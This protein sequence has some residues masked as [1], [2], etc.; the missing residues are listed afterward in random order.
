MNA[1][2]PVCVAIRAR[3][4]L[5]RGR[6]RHRGGSVAIGGTG[7]HQRHGRSVDGQRGQRS[8]GN[9]AAGS[10][11]GSSSAGMGGS[12]G[13]GA[14]TNQR[15]HRSSGSS[16]SG[17]CCR[18]RRHRG[19]GGAGGT[20]GTTGQLTRQDEAAPT[21][22]GGSS[23]RGGTSGSAGTGGGQGRSSGRGGT[24]GGAGTGGGQVD[25]SGRRRQRRH[26]AGGQRHRGAR[27]RNR[28][29]AVT[30]GQLF[31]LQHPWTTD[32]SGLPEGRDVRHDHQRPG[33]RGRVGTGQPLPQRREHHRP[34]GRR[35]HAAAHVHAHGRLLLARLRQ[36]SVPGA[37]RRAPSRAKTGYACTGDGDCH[38][39]VVQRGQKKLYEMWRANITGPASRSSGGCVAVWDLRKQYGSDAARQGLHVAPTP[40]GFPIARDAGDVRRGRG[41]ARR[42]RDALHPAQRRASADGIYVPPATHSTGPTSGGT[43][44]PPYGVRLRLK[45]GLRHQRA[46]VGREGARAGAA[47]TT[48]CSSPDGGNIAL[49]I[50]SDRYSTAKWSSLGI[51]NNRSLAALAVT[52]FEVVDY[53]TE[54]DW[55]ANT[56]CTR[57]P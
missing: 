41:R 8:A 31:D 42:P 45:A 43:A 51:T 20:A 34:A 27:T 26:R 2:D 44:T 35:R 5:P 54:V 49:T 24:S 37:R 32:V 46:V 12:A 30:T 22:Q 55:K 4:R 19:S 23:G 7:R 11:G 39:I 3:W 56:D 10:T 38:L 9:G 28:R 57:N 36:R 17:R 47:R 13:A 16:G 1:R 15:H 40:A 25:R 6:R 14:I 21:G 53:G 48:A 52:D 18:N 50:A 33:R 29:G